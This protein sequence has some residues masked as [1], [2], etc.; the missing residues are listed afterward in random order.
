MYKVLPLT[1]LVWLSFQFAL[2]AANT[3][4]KGH[5]P[6]YKNRKLNVLTYSDFLTMNADTLAQITVG[7]KGDFSIELTLAETRSIFIPLGFYKGLLLVEPGQS[8][9]IQLPPKK[10]SGPG[11]MLNPF[12]E[13]EEVYLNITNLQ[14]RELNT[15][16]RN[17]DEVYDQYLIQSTQDLI[18]KG[19]QSDV[20]SFIVFMDEKFNLDSLSYFKQHKS[21][22]FARL[23]GIAYERTAT[24][25]FMK[26][27]ANQPLLWH[28]EAYFNT[29]KSVANNFYIDFA[30]SE[31]G[32]SAHNSFMKDEDP[33]AMI[34][35]LTTFGKL[36]SDTLS[37]LVLIYNIYTR[38]YKESISKDFAI[39]VMKAI[40]GKSKIAS[41]KKVA[42]T[43]HKKFVALMP[44]YPAPE[45]TMKDINGKDA[46][47]RLF[48][49]KYLYL[50][51]Y[52]A[53]SY[54]AK[55]DLPLLNELYQKYNKWIEV[56][57]IAPKEDMESLQKINKKSEFNW[58][59]LFYEKENNLLQTYKIK[60]FPTYFMLDAENNFLLSP[61][62]SPT[63]EFEHTV[64]EIVIEKEREKQRKKKD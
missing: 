13:P 10:D 60:T 9:E 28:N 42:G 41:I 40:E 33:M 56:V 18:K 45:F 2:I 11:E 4:L 14:G 25:F 12:F 20:D 3:T 7:P 35:A 46:Q 50:H 32:A 59:F 64:S 16:S 43:I 47:L 15:F 55:Q 48:K 39:K 30:S 63:E 36:Q 57:T 19:R 23:R 17:F 44:G 6:D 21:Y 31:Q 29:F 27:Y 22:R 58:T 54:T 37:S 62:P 51:F 53:K 8:Y 34:R 1:L 24:S 5:A 49:G 52:S 61:A 26:Y 38:F